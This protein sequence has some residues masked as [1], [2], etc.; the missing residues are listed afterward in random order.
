MIL[1]LLYL[2]LT[3]NSLIMFLHPVLMWFSNIHCEA[4]HVDYKCP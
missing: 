3:L 1:L 2:K 4:D